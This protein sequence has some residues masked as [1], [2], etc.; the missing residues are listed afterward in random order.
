MGVANHRIPHLLFFHT[1]PARCKKKLWFFLLVIVYVWCYR[2]AIIRT[3]YLNNN[4]K[5]YRDFF[6]II[7][8]NCF[9]CNLLIYISFYKVSFSPIYLFLMYVSYDSFMMLMQ[10]LIIIYIIFK[11]NGILFLFSL[12]PLNLVCVSVY[13]SCTTRFHLIYRKQRSS[14]IILLLSRVTFSSLLFVLLFLECIILQLQTLTHLYYVF[15]TNWMELFSMSI[16]HGWSSKILFWLSLNVNLVILVRKNLVCTQ[17]IT[18]I[19]TI[20]LIVGRN[21]RWRN[22]RKWRRNM[23]LYNSFKR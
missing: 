11:R 19:V 7:L 23:L 16:Y 17:T 5:N 22:H 6:T 2:S 8:L 10:T 3:L 15:S 14:C 4:S 13:I 21:S 9:T 20:V 18:D 12:F 1:P